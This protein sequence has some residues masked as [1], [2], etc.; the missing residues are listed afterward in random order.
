MW[1]NSQQP[2]LSGSGR[3]DIIGLMTFDDGVNFFGKK[4]S[5]NLSV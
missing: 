4:E 2:M 1:P 3:I 5:S